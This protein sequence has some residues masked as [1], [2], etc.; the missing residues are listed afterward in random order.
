MEEPED[1]DELRDCVQSRIQRRRISTAVE[2][3]DGKMSVPSF[4]VTQ[5]LGW[6]PK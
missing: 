3:V 4:Q 1:A 5:G 6:D 2:L